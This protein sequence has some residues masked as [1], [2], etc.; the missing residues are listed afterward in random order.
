MPADQVARQPVQ[1]PQ[2]LS[3][4]HDLVGIE[5]EERVGNSEQRIGV[6]D[7]AVGFDPR[8][9]EALEPGGESKSSVSTGLGV[10]G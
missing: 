1:A 3:C 2:R 7:V 9:A 5:V 10:V 6:A 4:N 8:G